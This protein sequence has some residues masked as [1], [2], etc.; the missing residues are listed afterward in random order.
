MVLTHP[1]PD[2]FTM[3]KVVPRLQLCFYTSIKILILVY[4]LSSFRLLRESLYSISLFGKYL[5]STY[6]LRDIESGARGLQ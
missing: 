6:Y 2:Y 5:L 4:K 3:S 1:F